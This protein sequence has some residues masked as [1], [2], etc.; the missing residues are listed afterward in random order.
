M[1]TITEVGGAE[2][3]GEIP[4]PGELMLTPADPNRTLYFEHEGNRAVREGAWKLVALRDQ[5]WELYD[6]SNLRTEMKDLA[7][8]HPEIV[9][10]LSKK[11]D[12]WAT[13]NFVTPMPKDY[14]VKYLKVK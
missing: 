8:D 2:Y 12:T 5:P 14:Q 1:P 11:W 9:N 3:S 7:R 4:L 10:S 6:F 13:E